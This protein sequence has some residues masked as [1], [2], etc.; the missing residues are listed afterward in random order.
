MIHGTSDVLS[1]ADRQA[2]VETLEAL[3]SGEQ[4]TASLQACVESDDPLTVELH[5]MDDPTG[6]ARCAITI[7]ATVEEAVEYTPDNM[8]GFPNSLYD[9][10]DPAPDLA[11]DIEVLAQDVAQ[12]NIDAGLEYDEFDGG[13]ATYTASFLV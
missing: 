9:L 4:T 1:E 3:V 12:E 2:I 11:A 10:A 5:A 8:L 6:A 7:S 13:D